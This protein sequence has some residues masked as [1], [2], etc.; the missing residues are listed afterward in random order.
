MSGSSFL[1]C[2]QTLPR[3]VPRDV[4]EEISRLQGFCMI[5]KSIQGYGEMGGVKAD[6]GISEQITLYTPI[7]PTP[8]HCSFL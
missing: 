7:P 5:L 8:P 6:L 3:I 4:R 2:C 1:L